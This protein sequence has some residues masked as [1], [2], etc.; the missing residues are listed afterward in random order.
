MVS[1]DL[2]LFRLLRDRVFPSIALL[3][4]VHSTMNCSRN[5]STILGGEVDIDRVLFFC[6]D[7]IE[8]L[9]VHRR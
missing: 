9:S 8:K 7:A 1:H 2:K 3:L 5:F 4:Y 6:L